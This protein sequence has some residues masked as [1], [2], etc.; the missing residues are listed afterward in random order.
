MPAIRTGA[1]P[2]ENTRQL[3]LTGE[4]A[5]VTPLPSSSK[6]RSKKSSSDR[7]YTD[8]IFAIKPHFINLIVKREKN[9][10]YRK[11]EL[12]DTVT[13]I[14]LYEVAP[15][16]AI[17]HVMVTSR[18]KIPGEVCDSNG[19]GNDDFDNGMK[20]SKFGYPVLHLYKLKTPLRPEVMKKTY[21]VPTPQGYMYATKKMVDELPLEDME[22]LF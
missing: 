7:V 2:D 19:I 15:T 5:S 3:T 6:S 14:W 13:R 8:A 20:D 18:P 12:R 10:E 22:K 16:S 11:Y 4:L 1:K 21:G 9:H 17:S